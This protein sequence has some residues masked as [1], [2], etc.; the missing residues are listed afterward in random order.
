MT[1]KRPLVVPANLR[2]FQGTSKRVKRLNKRRPGN[3]MTSE[4]RMDANMES[5]DNDEEEKNLT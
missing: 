1:L 5:N 4:R 3:E 2:A